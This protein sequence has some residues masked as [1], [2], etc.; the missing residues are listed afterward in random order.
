MMG[1]ILTKDKDQKDPNPKNQTQAQQNEMEEVV[2]K[3]LLIICIVTVPLTFIKY[4]ETLKV[5]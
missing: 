5:L 4:V 2:H 3:T 1:E